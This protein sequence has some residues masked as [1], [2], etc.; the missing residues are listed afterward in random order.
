MN[1][2][3]YLRKYN[4]VGFAEVYLDRFN[5]ESKSN[6]EINIEVYTKLLQLDVKLGTTASE[7]LFGCLSNTTRSDVI[8][9][10]SFVSM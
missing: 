9:V 10:A 2:Y 6:D 3:E 8:K 1:E 7:Q 4:W 5:T